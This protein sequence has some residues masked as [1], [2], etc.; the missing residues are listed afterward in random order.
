MK[1]NENHQTALD[2]EKLIEIGL[3]TEQGNYSTFIDVKPRSGN[4]VF[5][6]DMNSLQ[7]Y[8]KEIKQKIK[9]AVGI[10]IIFLTVQFILQCYL[11]FNNLKDCDNKITE[12]SGMTDH[13][14]HYSK[15]ITYLCASY[16]IH[17]FFQI[18]FFTVAFLALYKQSKL[19]YQIFE[20]YILVMSMSDIFLCFLNS[21]NF[22]HIIENALNYLFLKY[23]IFLQSELDIVNIST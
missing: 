6:L 16:I 22:Y 15:G 14:H 5:V 1:S 12:I 4:P 10:F 11:S 3:Q 13:I 18:G 8:L 7:E 19:T 17:I 20:I 21:Y 9:I 23:L 2:N